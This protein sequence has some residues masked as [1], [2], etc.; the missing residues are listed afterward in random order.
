MRSLFVIIIVASCLIFLITGYVYWANE[1]RVHPSTP[2][3]PNI[4]N[5]INEL[6]SFGT[7]DIGEG[8]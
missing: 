6:R 7:E 2:N 4:P 5:N 3:G 8:D 1:T